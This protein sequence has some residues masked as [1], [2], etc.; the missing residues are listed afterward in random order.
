MATRM[1]NEG[2]NQDAIMER[3]EDDKDDFH[4]NDPRGDEYDG[5]IPF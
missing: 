5:P 3:L 1:H 4:R 2:M